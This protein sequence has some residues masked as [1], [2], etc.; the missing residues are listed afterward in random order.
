MLRALEKRL[1]DFRDRKIIE[2]LVRSHGFQKHIKTNIDAGIFNFGDHCI[3]FDPN[4]SMADWLRDHRGWWRDETMRIFDAMPRR[5]GTF[6]EVGANIGTQTIYAMLFG[7]FERAI[8]FEPDPRNAWYLK[9]NAA[10]NG[11]SDRI[12][13]VQAGCGA[14]KGSAQLSRSAA[15]WGQHSFAIDRGGDSITVPIVTVEEELA[16]LGVSKSD[17]TLAWIDVEG[18]ESEVLQ[19]WPS[20]PGSPLSIEFSPE[21][22]TLPGGVFAG[23]HQWAD[24]N[25]PVIRWRPVAELNVNKIDR[26]IDLMLI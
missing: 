3:A 14:A 21:W 7:G 24:T 20:L 5:G 12:T 6:V 15:H 11:F 22:G 9:I 17:I 23:W 13:I 10:I 16:R 1:R 25:E 19:G 26:Q 2:P 8:C 4:D 18:Y